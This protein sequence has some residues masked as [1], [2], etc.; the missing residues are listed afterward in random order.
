MIVAGMV[1][2][3]GCGGSDRPAPEP[4]TDPSSPATMAPD[5]PR[6]A[7]AARA[8]AAQDLVAVTSYTL[9]PP[10]GD[11]RQVVLVLAADG[12]WRVDIEGG[13]LGGTTDIAIAATGGDL[14]Q[15]AVPSLA[16]P[17]GA[18][19]RVTEL[20]PGIDP[21]VQ[22]VFT[23]WL[24]VFTDRAAALAVSAVPAPAEGTPGRCFGV[25][26][27]TASLQSPV[28]TGTY[29]F[30]DDGTITGAWLSLG[31]LRLERTSTAAPPTVDLPGPISDGDPL[32]T[33]PP[34]S[35]TGPASSGPSPLVG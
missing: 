13:A 32:P 18:C 14:F 7:L 27:T 4:T 15:C 23:D 16:R 35:P 30:A 5:S 9:T 28:D 1:V 26:S 34:P 25:E 20:T 31:T 8:A 6:A 10:G 2:T 24:R 33:A 12:T 29:C 19:V 21:R 22:H 11:E 3:G 17:D